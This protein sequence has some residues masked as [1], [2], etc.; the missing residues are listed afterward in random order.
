MVIV[1]FFTSTSFPAKTLTHTLVVLAVQ[2]FWME[3]GLGAEQLCPT[4][5]S[6]P[7]G[8]TAFLSCSLVLEALPA[9]PARGTSASS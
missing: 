9:F 8:C 5:T 2:E 1:L 4:F 6:D 3:L 7:K